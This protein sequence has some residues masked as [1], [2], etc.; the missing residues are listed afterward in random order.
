LAAWHN[1][2]GA[3]NYGAG[4]QL[5]SIAIVAITGFASKQTVPANTTPAAL[6][7]ANTTVNG[8]EDSPQ[9]GGNYGGSYCLS[10]PK[11]PSTGV[12]NASASF[13]LTGQDGAYKFTGDVSL[14]AANIGDSTNVSLFVNGD[15]YI[16]GDIRYTNTTWS[17]QAQI[18]SVVIVAHNIYIDPSVKRLDG[19]FVAT[20]SA[21]SADGNIFT[22]ANNS[23]PLASGSVY[24]S[25]NDQLLVHGSFVAKR[26][27]FMRSYGTLKDNITNVAC[28][29][30]GNAAGTTN[31]AC[32]AEVFEFSP[33]LYLSNPAIQP[34]SNGAVHYDSIVN[35]PPIL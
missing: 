20:D 31:A 2:I 32:A 3:N 8:D 10:Q 24:D 16:R 4:A 5:S 21:S 15:V 19:M 23:G 22:C 1:N 14:S 13:D 17:N 28:H 34:Q 6:S 27:H 12:N 33:E 11:Q 35:M 7:F 25:C 29:N 26:V 9:L 30:A 18:P